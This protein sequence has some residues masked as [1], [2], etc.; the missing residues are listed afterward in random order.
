MNLG[1]HL[2][3]QNGKLLRLDFVWADLTSDKRP[4]APGE[5]AETIITLPPLEKGDYEIEIDCVANRVGW[6]AQFGS[7]PARVAIHI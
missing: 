7:K 2:Y 1:C 4:I 6:F 5:S 3:D